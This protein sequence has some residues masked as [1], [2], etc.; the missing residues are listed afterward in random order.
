[1]TRVTVYQDPDGRPRGFEVSGHADDSAVEG[2][3]IVCAAI[4]ALTIT[5]VNALEEF[6]EDDFEGESDEESGRIFLMLD[7]SPSEAAELLLK[8]LIL[9][10]TGIRENRSYRDL[11]S[12][13]FTEVQK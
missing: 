8:T 10:F 2:N 6:T 3:D 9:G 12:I 13:V 1:M 11:I 7:G 4:S 5:C